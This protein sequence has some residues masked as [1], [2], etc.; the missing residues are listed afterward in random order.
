MKRRKEEELTAEDKAVRDVRISRLDPGASEKGTGQQKWESRP[1]GIWLKRSAEHQES[2]SKDVVTGV[3]VLFG[4]DA[5]EPRLGWDIKDTPLSISSSGD[6]QEARLSIRG[7]RPGKVDRPALRVP[8]DGKFKILQV[9][10]MHLSTGM[11]MCR[12]PEPAGYN[13]G[14][15]DADPRTL[16]FIGRILD[17]EKPDLAVLTGDQVNGDSSP[18]TQSV[19]MHLSISL[20]ANAD[21]STSG[22]F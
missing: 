3:D 10:D 21:A 4:A 18:D 2:D 8:K 13:G 12:D 7:G 6:S 20:L 14:R 9:G 17:D 11:G 1:A 15:C 22:D 5:V 19:C 16:E